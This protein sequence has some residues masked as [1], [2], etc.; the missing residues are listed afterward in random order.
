[1]VH[2]M[3]NKTGSSSFAAYA[4]ASSL[5]AM[6]EPKRE[7][8]LVKQ[9]QTTGCTKSKHQIIE[10]HLRYVMTI[11][12]QLAGG[13]DD[14]EDLIQEGCVGLITALDKFELDKGFRFA[15]YATHWVKSAVKQYMI[16]N[17][18]IF[19]IATTKAQRKCYY[20]LYT[21]KKE[22]R[23]FSQREVENIAEVLNVPVEDVREMEKKLIGVDLSI[24]MDPEHNAELLNSLFTELDDPAFLVEQVDWEEK[25]AGTIELAISSLDDRSRSII[26]D[27]WFVKDAKTLHELGAIHNVSHERI[28]QLETKS[29]NAIKASLRQLAA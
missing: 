6:L 19:R 1:M 3:I 15:V 10:S 23:V 11:V 12:R 21:F 26:N 28:R 16:D 20:N 18:R 8:E 13:R 29:M 22:G 7:Y 25:V 24:H 5:Y 17:A 27:R 9:Y 4:Q 14:R 2:K